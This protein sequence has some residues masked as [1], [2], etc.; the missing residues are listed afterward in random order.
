MWSRLVVGV[1]VAGCGRLGFD[2]GGG[3]SGGDGGTAG[4]LDPG[5]GDI[6]PDG[7]PCGS[8]GMPITNSA[9]VTQTAGQ[10]KVTP[11]ANTFGASG[12]CSR[13]NVMVT[14]GGAFVEVEQTLNASAMTGLTAMQLEYSSVT[15]RLGVLGGMLDVNDG[16]N[17]STSPYDPVAQRWWRIRPVDNRMSFE[18]SADGMQWAQVHELPVVPSGP[19]Q[20]DVVALTALAEPAPGTAIFDGVDVCP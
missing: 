17:D 14:S 16:S 4:C 9:E 5:D 3:S 7:V 1:C 15:L 18:V 8:W 13:T 2:P 6:F 11:D 12:G 19:A 10:L 20:L